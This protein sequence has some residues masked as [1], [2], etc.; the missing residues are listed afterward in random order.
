MD[1]LPGWA[2]AVLVPLISIILAALITVFV[3]TLRQPDLHAPTIGLLLCATRSDAVVRYALDSTV[4]EGL[5]SEVWNEIDALDIETVSGP[6]SAIRSVG[7]LRLVSQLT[8]AD[9]LDTQLAAGDIVTGLQL[10]P[11]AVGTGAA[12]GVACATSLRG[13]DTEECVPDPA[14]PTR[15]FTRPDN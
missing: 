9:T 7:R 4:A 10:V 5:T 14:P 15:N 6:G 2:D 13:H 12:A 11:I 8:E 1:R 3:Y